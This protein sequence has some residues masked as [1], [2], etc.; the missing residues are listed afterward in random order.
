MEAVHAHE[1]A[2]VIDRD[3]ALLLGYALGLGRRGI[4][5]HEGQP[6]DAPIEAVAAQDA[7]DPVGTDPDPAPALLG[8]GGADASR[9]EAR[10]T[11]AEGHDPGLDDR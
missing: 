9:A 1:L 2:R 11:K 5:G 4:A 10:V 8:Q 6:A 7:P 3:V